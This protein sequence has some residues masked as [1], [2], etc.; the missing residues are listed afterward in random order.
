MPPLVEADLHEQIIENAARLLADAKFL[1]EN[2]RY[3]SAFAL[4][5]LGVEEIGKAILKAW[6]V[7]EPLPKTKGRR[8]LHIEKQTAVGALLVAS[9]AIK[10]FSDLFVAEVPMAET[11]LEDLT[12]AFNESDEGQLLYHIENRALEK[13]K[14]LAMY[15]DEWLTLGSSNSDQ[16]NDV[17]VNSILE[18]ATGAANA[19]ADAHIMHVGEIIYRS[20]ST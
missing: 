7:V 4:A 11:F 14:H 19:I 5:V 1:A 18:I 17:H 3:A 16:F 2:S 12:K 15:R 9:F 8:S 13:R 10:N 6:S 20:K